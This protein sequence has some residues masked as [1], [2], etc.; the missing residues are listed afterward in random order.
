MRVIFEDNIADDQVEC[1]GI[2]VPL[3]KKSLFGKTREERYERVRSI[4]L[5]AIETFSDYIQGDIRVSLASAWTRYYVFRIEADRTYALNVIAPNSELESF[6]KIVD[7][8][9]QLIEAFPHNVAKPLACTDEF[10]LQE[11][12]DGLPLSEFRDG[13]I[14]KDVENAKRCIP[15]ASY[16]LWKFNELGFVYYPWDDYEVA[17]CDGRLVFLDVTRFVRRRLRPEEF[18]DFYFGAPFTPPEIVKPSDDPAHRLYWRGVSEK[19]YFGTSRRE[20]V[21]LFLAGVAAACENYETFLR[22]CDADAEKIW[23]IGEK[24][25]DE[26]QWG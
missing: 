20:Y 4:V 2:S 1:W 24:L 10:M 14:I 8:V 12:I 22:V 17:L 15:M 21:E 11:W 19:D 25:K 26:I 5:E 13:D 3:L 6:R 16:L 18:F 7:A 9:S 23:K